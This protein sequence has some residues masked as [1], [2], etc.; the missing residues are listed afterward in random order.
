VYE[1]YKAGKPSRRPAV[2]DGLTD[3]KWRKD[4]T[5]SSAAVLGDWR[6]MLRTEGISGNSD[7][8]GQ[9][10]GADSIAKKVFPA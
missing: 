4:I 7:I 6:L 10:V 9:I 3:V 1:W 5:R 2:I 8:M